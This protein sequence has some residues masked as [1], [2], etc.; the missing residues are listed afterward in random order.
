MRFFGARK[1]S[2]VIITVA[3]AAASLITVGA[4]AATLMFGVV[5]SDFSSSL[6]DMST[7]GL[8]LASFFLIG[9]GV[10]SRKRSV[11]LS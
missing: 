4:S 11:V 7:G 9:A 8:M 2:A 6:P 10:R 1:T 5:Q 3:V